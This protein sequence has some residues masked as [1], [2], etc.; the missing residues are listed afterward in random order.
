MIKNLNERGL[1]EMNKGKVD[2]AYRILKHVETLCTV[3][4]YTNDVNYKI[5]VYNHLGCCLRRLGKLKSAL[6]YLVN[7][8]KVIKASG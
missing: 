5:I 4:H 3:G 7:A 6:K 1:K 8:M 2:A